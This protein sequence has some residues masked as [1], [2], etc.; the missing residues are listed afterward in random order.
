MHRADR[1]GDGSLCVL[2][3]FQ[4]RFD[5]CFEI[6]RI[7]H[8]VEDA[9]YIDAGVGGALDKCL[10][11]VVGVVAITQQIL[12]TQQH[13]LRGVRHRR[14]QQTQTLPG[15]FTQKT[16]TG[17]ESCPAPALQRPVTDLIQL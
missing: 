2:A 13:L 14:L 6:A 4:G 15:I 3:A 1:I 17:I 7:I 5:G 8:G 11:N 9:E 12:S 10:D 16:D